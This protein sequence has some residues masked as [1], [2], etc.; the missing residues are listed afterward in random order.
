M[1]K[2]LY[3]QHELAEMFLVKFWV[4]STA[5]S[6]K[7]LIYFMNIAIQIS[8]E[9]ISHSKDLKLKLQYLE[10]STKENINNYI[11]TFFKE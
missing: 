5:R 4:A 11:Y 10:S 9:N 8:C 6:N 1:K 7:I 3:Q 2:N